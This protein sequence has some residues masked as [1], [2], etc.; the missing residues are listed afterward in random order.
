MVP[1]GVE[2]RN[3]DVAEQRKKVVVKR[4]VAVGEIAVVE[5]KIGILCIDCIDY[6]AEPRFPR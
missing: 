3:T 1:D 5:N 4:T 2:L 6:A